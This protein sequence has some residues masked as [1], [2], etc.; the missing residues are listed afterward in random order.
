MI[1]SYITFHDTDTNEMYR[2]DGGDWIEYCEG[3]LKA[4]WQNLIYVLDEEG[5][6]AIA[7]DVRHVAGAI[8]SYLEY[9]KSEDEDES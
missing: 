7:M 3:G 8:A 1:L 9:V 6:P 2:Y 4:E 5:N